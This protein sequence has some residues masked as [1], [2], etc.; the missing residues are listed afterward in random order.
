[1]ILVLAETTMPLLAI[2]ALVEIFKEKID[3]KKLLNYFYIALG[4]TGLTVMAFI[5]VPSITGL[6]GEGKAEVNQAE[7]LASY[8][9]KEEQYNQ[10]KEEFKTDYINAIYEDR[11]KMVRDDALR[12]LVFIILGAGVVFLVIKKKIN[13]KIAIAA[14]AVIV[15][16]DM[17]P[18]NKRYLNDEKF[19]SKRKY[20]VPYEK[21]LADNFI[22]ADKDKHY[23][24]SDIS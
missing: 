19:V 22:L 8:F 3:A 24:V 9:P 12:S 17:W 15:L 6:S 16:A 5:A 4:I 21:S 14:M 11:A 13:P 1:M 10:A 23:R 7:Y 2:L 18:I 20:E